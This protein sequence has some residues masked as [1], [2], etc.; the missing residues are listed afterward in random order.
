MPLLSS[1]RLATFARLI[2]SGYPPILAAKGAGYRNP[3]AS[4]AAARLARPRSA[5][6]A[7]ARPALPPM[8]TEEEWL[9]EFA[10]LMRDKRA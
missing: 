1:F 2:A 8:M 7:V 6:A 9:A 10:P 3:C 4:R 5:P